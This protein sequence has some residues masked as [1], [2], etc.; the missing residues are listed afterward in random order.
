M[1]EHQ[2]E[3]SVVL[4]GI[5]NGLLGS[6]FF[7]MLYF[8]E[9]TGYYLLVLLTIGLG[10]RPLLEKTGLYHYLSDSAQRLDLYL[11]RKK[12]DS[13]RANIDRK[14]RDDKYRKSRSRDKDPRLPKNW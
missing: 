8:T 9:Y 5:Y 7:V 10:L 1:K 12:L 11:H 3:Y 14:V 2:F 6:S 13:H 4:R